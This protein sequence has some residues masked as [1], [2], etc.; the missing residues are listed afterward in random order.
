MTTHSQFGEDLIIQEYFDDNPELALNHRVVE[1][2]ALDG[3]QC[4]N[5]RMFSG[6][7]WNCLLVE[8][9]PDSFNKLT[10][11]ARESDTVVGAAICLEDGPV[12]FWVNEEP[13]WSQVRVNGE[14]SR[15]GRSTRTEIVRGITLETLLNEN[16]KYWSSAGE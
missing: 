13:S 4:S 9:N 1:L 5:S 14:G 12:E 11:N 16:S 15:K 3:V 8:P 7:G 6:M 2:G 10:L